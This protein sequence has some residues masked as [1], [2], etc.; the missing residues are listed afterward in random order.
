MPELTCHCGAVHITVDV[1]PETVTSCNCSIC[2]RTGALLAYYSPRQ[3]RFTPSPP[4]TDT[5]MCGDNSMVFHR[6]KTCG[7][8]THWLSVDPAYDRMGVN[9]RL[10]DPEV[11]AKVR[12]RPF[13]GA[14]TWKFL[15][16]ETR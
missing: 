4:P 8:H 11:L 14:D 10:A 9:M 7:C 6:C 16:G 15:D 2:R 3:V 1:A 5:Y 13:D 12:I